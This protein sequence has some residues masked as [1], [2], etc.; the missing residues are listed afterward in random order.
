MS[1]AAATEGSPKYDP[2]CPQ[3]VARYEAGKNAPWVEQYP[4][5]EHCH[6]S[7]PKRAK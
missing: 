5:V 1:T 3:C 2:H 7:C 4:W 6:F